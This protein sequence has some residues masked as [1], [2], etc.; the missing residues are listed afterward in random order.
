MY[1]RYEKQVRIAYIWI[2]RMRYA[3]QYNAALLLYSTILHSSAFFH[4]VTVGKQSIKSTFSTV[5]SKHS[6]LL[7]S[8]ISLEEWH[9]PSILCAVYNSK[10]FDFTTDFHNI[11][12][13]DTSLSCENSSNKMRASSV[14]IREEINGFLTSFL[15]SSQKSW[16]RSLVLDMAEQAPPRLKEQW[17]YSDLVNATT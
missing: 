13:I 1:A 6:I 14:L 4:F 11:E 7:Q 17:K 3:L 15:R 9:V 16:C 8:S 5:S 2:L 10:N 12:D